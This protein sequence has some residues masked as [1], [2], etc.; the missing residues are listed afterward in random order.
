MLDK[1]AKP[2]IILIVLSL[3]AWMGLGTYRYYTH[4]EAPIITI[5]GLTEG[6]HYKE[7]LSAKV[8]ANNP[9]KIATID[10]SLDGKPYADFS[11][12][13]NSSSFSKP[14]TINT[15]ALEDGKHLITFE[16]CDGSKNKN[17]S[18]LAIPFYVDNAPLKTTFADQALRVDQGKTAHI[19]I[20]ANKQLATVLVTCLAKT[21]ECYP[22]SPESTMYECFIPID[23]EEKAGQH[24]LTAELHDYVQN[25]AKLSNYLEIVPFDFPKQK[26]FSVSS[27]KLENEKEVSMSNK[28]L[29][30]AVEK[31]GAQSPKH[32]LWN[33]PFEMPILVR[34][35]TTPFGEIRTTPE[36]G[37][38]LH[39]GLDLINMPKSVV[40]ASQN[41]KVIIKDRYLLTGNTVVIDHGLGVT[42]LYAH[43]DT[44]ADIE[45]GDMLKKGNP[46][47]T[48]GMTGYAAGYHLHWELRINNIAVDPYE[49][50]TRV[51]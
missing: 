25:S 20:Q 45:V 28:I 17:R 4:K 49:W 21:Y 23:C 47:G 24:T 3:S 13:I 51:Y 10:I 41:G 1:Y 5:E 31:W 40:W 14:L 39:K 43:L 37:R 35:Q 6:G 18:S 32:K 9:Y 7:T 22:D 2:G 12:R 29:N 15:L 33:G 26:G 36:R 34:R 48:I 42:T 44:F 30:E 50:T 38:Y 16:L 46:V 11:P 19:K 8:V 27:Q